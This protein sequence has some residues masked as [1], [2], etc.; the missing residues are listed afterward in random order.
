MS[1][2][3]LY[4]I[5]RFAVVG[6]ASFLVDYGTLYFCT[7]KCGI[8]YLYS[9]AIAF[10]LSVIFNYWLCVRF[11]FRNTGKQTLKQAFFFVGSSIMGLFLNQLC[12]W[13]FV[14]IIAFYYMLAKVFS[15]ALVMLWNYIMKRK[16]IN[17][18]S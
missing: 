12:M 8:Y 1:K 18:T 15:T 16:A 5:V 4:E 10:T 9:S 14:D 11:V 2:V 17:Y 6:F 13:F 7:E 3:R